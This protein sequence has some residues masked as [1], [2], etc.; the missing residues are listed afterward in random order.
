MQ[1]SKYAY[2]F[3]NN[4]ARNDIMNKKQLVCW[5]NFLGNFGAKK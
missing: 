5:C 2:I 3:E 1:I 4:V